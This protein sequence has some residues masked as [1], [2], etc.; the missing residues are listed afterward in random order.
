[1]DEVQTEIIVQEDYDNTPIKAFLR[2]FNI[3]FAQ[4]DHARVLASVT[5]DIYWKAVG[6]QV[7]QGKK[8]LQEALLAMGAERAIKLTIHTIITNDT[9]AAANGEL[10]FGNGE[11]YAFCDIYRFNNTGEHA[12]ISEMTSYVVKTST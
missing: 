4:V 12:R 1:M 10:T 11:T 3:A 7:V 2:D 8:A 6:D 9:T 5:D